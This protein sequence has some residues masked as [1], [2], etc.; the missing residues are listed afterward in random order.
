[1]LEGA[2]WNHKPCDVTWFCSVGSH[3]LCCAGDCAG[4]A[5]WEKPVSCP[6]GQTSFYSEWQS[7]S[8]EIQ[9][10]F[11]KKP[12]WVDR[13]PL[14]SLRSQSE[15]SF[16]W[17]VLV[18]FCHSVSGDTTTARLR[19]PSLLWRRTLVPI[20]GKA[21]PNVIC[22]LFCPLSLLSVFSPCARSSWSLCCDC[23][24]GADKS[25]KYFTHTHTLWANQTSGI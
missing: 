12:N 3:R 14:A 4:Q 18:P 6:T 19:L 9:E 7:L 8:P 20:T 10:W 24:I 23:D 21:I 22:A 11:L 17:S 1:M 25:G 16:V 2:G 13:K 15:F 5:L